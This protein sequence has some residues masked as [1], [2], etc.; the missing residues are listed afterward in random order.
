MKRFLPILS[1]AFLAACNTSPKEDI[2]SSTS[3]VQQT[4]AIDTT[5]FAQYQAWRTQ[6]EVAA[7][8]E[9]SEPQ[10]AVAPIQKAPIRKAAPVRKASKPKAAPISSPAPS[11]TSE[12][13]SVAS[14]GMSSESS[15]PAKAEK[16]GISKAAKGA[17][18]GG[19]AGAAGGAVL[20]KKNRVVGAVIGAVIGAGGGYVVGRQMDKKDG[21]IDYT[22]PGFNMVNN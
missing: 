5:G 16:K 14:G 1:I 3:T 13:N 6:N 21:R 9:Y 19:V 10:Q 12:D 15:Q 17:V 7:I 11:S 8:E 4:P 22:T 20:N 2:A 18:I